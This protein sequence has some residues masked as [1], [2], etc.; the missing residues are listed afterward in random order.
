MDTRAVI[1]NIVSNSST[2]SQKTG[3]SKAKYIKRKESK[4]S[5]IFVPLRPS[6]Q[7]VSE[8]YFERNPEKICGMRLDSLSQMLSFANIRS[9]G[10]YFVLDDTHGMV[11]AAIM[12]RMGGNGVVVAVHESVN[13]PFDIVRYMN[14]EK[15]VQ[16]TLHTI[17]WKTFLDESKQG[18]PNEPLTDSGND[19]HPSRFDR[20]VYFKAQLRVIR[21][22]CAEAAFDGLIVVGSTYRP[23]EVVESF[24]KYLAGSKPVVVYTEAVQPLLETYKSLRLNADYIKVEMSDIWTREYQV[25]FFCVSTI[26]Y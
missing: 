18:H 5:K 16:D 20:K 12:E 1:E 8:F 17:Q 21:S 13:S 23:F 4:F 2:Y 3:F 11:L 25:R 15:V 7:T 14:F 6:I 10:K 19:V 24:G 22:L 26:G 9:G